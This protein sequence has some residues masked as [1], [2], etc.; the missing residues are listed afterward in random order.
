[1]TLAFPSFG[2]GVSQRD[3]NG[4]IDVKR[5]LTGYMSWVMRQHSVVVVKAGS[6]LE[7]IQTV[8]PV[9][10]A[11]TILFPLII[12][13]STTSDPGVVVQATASTKN[14]TPGVLWFKAMTLLVF[15]QRGRVL[16]IVFA[17]YQMES[18]GRS[19]DLRNIQW[20]TVWLLDQMSQVILCQQRTWVLLLSQGY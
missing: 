19:R 3:W 16:P 6:F 10:I 20:I 14:F 13:L 15:E 18:Q 1:M 7:V 8:F 9:P 4:R 5:A 12:G 11:S 17:F 2:D